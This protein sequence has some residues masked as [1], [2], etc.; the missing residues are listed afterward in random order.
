MAGRSGIR[1]GAI[2]A[3]P[4]LVLLAGC[5][6]RRPEPGAPPAGSDDPRGHDDW[7]TDRAEET[8]LDFVHFNGASG[9][10]YYP[11]IL[12]PGVALFD[13]DNDGDL[14]VYLVQGRTIESAAVVGSGLGR[15]DPASGQ[16][17]GS[18]LIAGHGPLPAKPGGRR[19]EAVRGRTIPSIRWAIS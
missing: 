16:A 10:F 19:N 13:F 15:I 14:D 9:D 12:P 4:A 8:G 5:A 11:E 18:A 3:L 7:F 2:I 17:P 6:D 1:L